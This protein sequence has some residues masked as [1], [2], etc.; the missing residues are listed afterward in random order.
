[1]VT[2]KFGKSR[3]E[4][5]A[6]NAGASTSSTDSQPN[7]ECT[8]QQNER[9]SGTEHYADCRIS[10]RKQESSK[11]RH[12]STDSDSSL[13]DIPPLPSASVN[14]ENRE[15]KDKDDTDEEGPDY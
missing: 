5:F 7:H 14:V 8:C 9:A 10:Q 6:V 4:G 2:L 15:D 1:M 3:H 13:P 12:E 11:F